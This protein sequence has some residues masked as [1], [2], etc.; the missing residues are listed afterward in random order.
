VL[1]RRSVN[2]GRLEHA[3]PFDHQIAV[4]LDGQHDALGGDR[5]PDVHARRQ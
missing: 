1:R 5:R 2:V 4:R 3:F